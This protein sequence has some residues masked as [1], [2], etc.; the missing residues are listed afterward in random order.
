MQSLKSIRLAEVDNFFKQSFEQ[1][2]TDSTVQQ[3]LVHS[4]IRVSKVRGSS[5]CTLWVLFFDQ[6]SL[7]LQRFEMNF[8]LSKAKDDIEK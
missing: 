6:K 4:N 3:T 7:V 8:V 5:S 1:K 2:K